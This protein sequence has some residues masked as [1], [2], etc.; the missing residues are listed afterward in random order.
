MDKKKKRCGRGCDTPWAAGP[1]DFL[2]RVPAWNYVVPWILDQVLLSKLLES[3][4]SIVDQIT[5]LDLITI[6]HVCNRLIVTSNMVHGKAAGRHN[7]VGG[8]NPR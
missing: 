3:Q 8:L 7:G 2:L 1:A 4:V 6:L 5:A